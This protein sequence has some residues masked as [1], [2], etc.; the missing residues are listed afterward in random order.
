MEPKTAPTTLSMRSLRERQR[1]ERAALILEAAQQI[2]SEK[3]YVEASIDEIAARTGIAKGTVYLHFA[4]KEE[5]V[6][7]L[8]E[9]QFKQFLQQIEHILS[10]AMPMRLRLEHLLLDV[11]TRIQAQ[12]NQVL[13]DL[14]PR[15]GLTTS[16]INKRPDLAA[17]S[18]QAMELISGLISEG[19]TNG[20]LDPKVPSM[21]M[22]A[23]LV[24]MLS[25]NSYERL[26]ASGLITPA[27][28]AGYL[29]RSFF[30]KP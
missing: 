30:P 12:G 21:V 9:Q 1:E 15:L 2:F 27:E 25:P 22:V 14:N 18:T 26:L 6:V 17:Y 3:G 20:E 19:Q 24:N 4:S 5:L 28:L 23:T 29:S 10:E 8:F 7:A 13:I 11:Y 16:L